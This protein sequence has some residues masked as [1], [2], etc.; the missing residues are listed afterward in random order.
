MEV[1]DVIPLSKSGRALLVNPD[2]QARHTGRTFRSV[3]ERMLQT[4]LYEAGAL[5]LLC[6]VFSLATGMEVAGSLALL[7]VLSLIEMLVSALHNLAFDHLDWSWTGRTASQRTPAWRIAHAVSYEVVATIVSLPVLILGAGLSLAAALFADIALSA[8]C[9]CYTYA[10]FAVY[11][12]LQPLAGRADRDAIAAAPASL[13]EEP[14]TAVELGPEGIPIPA[15]SPGINA[16]H[17]PDCRELHRGEEQETTK[18]LHPRIGKKA[19]S[20]AGTSGR[21]ASPGKLD[22]GAFM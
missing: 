17:F 12:R 18:T 3:S 10:F 9:A 14:Q 11:D 16:Q 8:L 21:K 19:V 7:V 13:G 2:A 6:P 1:H 5:I 22:D 15:L 20:E 4:A